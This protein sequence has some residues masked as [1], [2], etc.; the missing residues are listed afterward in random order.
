M[1][2]NRSTW[3]NQVNN[4]VDGITNQPKIAACWFNK[5]YSHALAFHCKST[6]ILLHQP[7]STSMCN[8]WHLQAPNRFKMLFGTC[9]HAYQ[10]IKAI[11]INNHMIESPDMN[12]IRRRKKKWK[13]EHF[14]PTSN[15]CK[16]KSHEI[17][18]RTTITWIFMWCSQ[19]IVK[20]FIRIHSMVCT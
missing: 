15:K 17:L 3:C 19:T 12:T 9:F 1:F 11:Q 13:S 10:Q 18:L 6:N 5:Q 16:S 4:F 20:W 7:I 2:D 14:S 8:K